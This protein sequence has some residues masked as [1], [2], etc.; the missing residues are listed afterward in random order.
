MNECEDTSSSGTRSRR[1]VLKAAVAGAGAVAAVGVGGSVARA[2]ERRCAAPVFVLVHGA[3]GNSY[4]WAPVVAEL[5]L[6]G[7]KAVA[8]DLPGHG[9]G[10]YYPVSY[11]TPQDLEALRTEPSPLGKVTLDDF[12]E[13]VVGVVRRA[14]RLGAV[15][16][17]GQ[18]MGGVT[19]NA[20][21]NRVPE[22]ISH[23]VYASAFC[24][25]GHTSAAQLMSTP[26]G[27]TSA[28]L[29]LDRVETP[30]GLGVNRANWRSGDP[31]F[32]AAAKEALAAD[33][34]DAAVRALIATLEP[35]ES[36]AIGTADSRGLPEKW[37][38]VPRTFLR[39][40]QDRA[41]PLALQDLMIRE[42]D[43]AT[44]RNRFRVRSLAAPHV[45]P[46]DAAVWADELELAAGSCR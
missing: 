29:R 33:W 28:L 38:R 31:A 14:S 16:L 42:A 8:V 46:R 34:P 21:A 41:I 22:L 27:S 6:R 25:T 1:G 2:D 18:S 39:F 36:A 44:P 35:D 20:V 24:A 4:G 12:A 17:V 10:A 15:V 43:A 30:P 26:E 13:H 11:Q 32:F 45:G 23:L 7:H 5:A 19:L 3:G 40:T 9:R 37:G